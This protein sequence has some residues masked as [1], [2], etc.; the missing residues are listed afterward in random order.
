MPSFIGPDDIRPRPA[1][2]VRRPKRRRLYPTDEKYWSPYS[3][4]IRGTRARTEDGTFV[5]TG[6]RAGSYRLATILDAQFGAWFDP[7]Y[8]RA[9][10]STST[11]V[12]F[13]SSEHKIINLRV[14]GDR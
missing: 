2:A 9:I 13:A 3:L 12:S 5:I 1:P 11:S 10:D 7:A 6:I 14:P 4:R 8:L